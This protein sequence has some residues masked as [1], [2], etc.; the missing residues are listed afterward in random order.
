MEGVNLGFASD[1]NTSAY[2]LYIPS[3]RQIIVTN[4][5]VFD[6]SFFPNNEVTIQE[7]PFQSAAMYLPH[8]WAC[9]SQDRS[10]SI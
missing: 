7:V 4:Q 8:P 2:K 10:D 1:R 6:E 9:H 5:V 3:T